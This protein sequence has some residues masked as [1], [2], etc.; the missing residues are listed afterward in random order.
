MS[1]SFPSFRVFLAASAILFQS[2]ASIGQSQSTRT[3]HAL[4]VSVG[5]YA[6]G[7]GWPETSAAQDAA[8]MVRSLSVRGFDTLRNVQ[9]LT[10]ALATRAGIEAAMGELTK[11]VKAGDLVVVQVSAHGV[12]LRDVNSDETDG[13][14]E[15]IAPYDGLSPLA[16][17]SAEEKGKGYLTD[18]DFERLV[19]PLRK[20]LSP[21]GGLLVLL[22]I[23]YAAATPGA[24]AR[25]RGMGIAVVPELRPKEPVASDAE[26][27][28]FREA[29]SYKGP[30]SG[31]SPCAFISSSDAQ[32]A[33]TDVRPAS[34][35]GFGALTYAFVRALSETHPSESLISLFGRMQTQAALLSPGRQLVLEVD[36]PERPLFDGAL[37]AGPELA[38]RRPDRDG[39][40]L[41]S[42][43]LSAGL[44]DSSRVAFFRKGVRD[45]LAEKSPRLAEGYVVSAT[46][47]EA[48]L[49]G[50]RLP[51]GQAPATL[52]GQVV[53]KAW[54]HASPTLDFVASKTGPGSGSIRDLF[55]DDE[56]QALRDRFTGVDILRL[57]PD[58]DLLVRKGVRDDEVVDASTGR[59][60]GQMEEGP[61]MAEQILGIVRRYSHGRML[62]EE[63]PSA[64]LQVSMVLVPVVGGQPLPVGSKTRLQ[65]GY[66]TF[67]QGE[68]AALVV[69][70][71]NTFPVYVSVFEILPEG[72]VRYMLPDA[73][74]RLRAEDAIV[75]PG[76]EAVFSDA[77]MLLRIEGATGHRVLKAFVSREPLDLSVLADPE[78]MGQD[79]RPRGVGFGRLTALGYEAGRRTVRVPM[80]AG[81]ATNLH[82]SVQSAA[83]AKG[84]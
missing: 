35:G 62:M 2:A 30:E 29:S 42:P 44:S 81:L 84:R 4:L 21:T 63:Q 27:H 11:R 75:P 82:L 69:S 48:R 72:S 28:L 50:L 17:A 78:G 45:P 14:D 38:L 83:P 36:I 66:W 37:A 10:D 8:L 71:P 3:R 40:W 19:L 59:V 51:A 55:R 79:A 46:A 5:R 61:D 9:R 33:A 49:K 18:D 53:E 15:A 39:A 13:L 80:G 1:F 70:N 6:S 31:Y 56:L 34:D 20:K 74:K 54:T 24:T 12:Q 68:E 47:T 43:G 64:N 25:H 26:T 77:R 58:A 57:G 60:I 67:A 32:T 16:P 41:V 73:G 52:A 76:Q 65:G 23:G 22:D 7:T